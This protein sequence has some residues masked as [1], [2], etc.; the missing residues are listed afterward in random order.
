MGYAN[1]ELR[2]HHYNTISQILSLL[3]HYQLL[4]DSN[5]HTLQIFESQQN[6]SPI[7]NLRT[8]FEAAAEKASTAI[9]LLSRY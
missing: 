5:W 1:K 6:F 9:S 2:Q 8:V 3:I 7:V 4:I